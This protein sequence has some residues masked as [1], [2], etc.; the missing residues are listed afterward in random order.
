MPTAFILNVDD[1]APGR[2]SRTKILT[3][4]GFEV[5]EAATGSEALQMAKENPQ[6]IL[7]DVNLPDINGLEVCRRIKENP[8][9]ARTIVLHLSASNVLPEHRVA[10]LENGAD[11]YL[12]EPVAPTVLIATIR[13]LLRA[14]AA[15]EALRHSNSEL[16]HFAT[17]ISHELREPLRSVSTYTEL[18]HAKLAGRLEASEEQYMTQM[19]AGTRRMNQR[20]SSIL[21][22]SRAEHGRSD[23]SDI[24]AEEMLTEVLDELQL[25][26]AQAG[27]K[28]E[29]EP[30]PTVRANRIGLSRVFANL[31]TNAIKYRGAERPVI[32]IS[33]VPHG[34]HY[35]FAIRDNGTGIDPLFHHQ[36]FDPFK[37][38]HGPELSGAGLG[39][40]LCRR[41]IKSCGGEIWVDSSPGNG[42]TFYFTL[43]APPES[44]AF[45]Q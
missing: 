15:E 12:T 13:A 19:L 7:L 3:Q 6:L 40:A 42:S 10:G 44:A 43:P 8:E 2:Y 5:R 4:A 23:I 34:E 35:L 22:Y 32:T 33:V 16:E 24:S 11:S 29:H 39:L 14:H 38:L 36:I 30:L 17:M 1:Y 41:V 37:R 21:E 31:I 18:L 45:P 20:I 9:T 26:V 27:A 28:I 25:L